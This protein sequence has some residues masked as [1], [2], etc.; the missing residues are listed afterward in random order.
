MSQSIGWP[1]Q[2]IGIDAIASTGES[3]ITEVGVRV[4]QPWYSD[5]TGCVVT[6][7]AGGTGFDLG[8]EA[9]FDDDVHARAKFQA[10]AEDAPDIPQ[11]STVHRVT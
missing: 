6:D 8:N 10:R 5:Q 4:D 9:V 2:R 7:V 1:Q 11:R 3:R